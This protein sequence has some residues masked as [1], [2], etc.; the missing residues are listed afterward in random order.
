MEKTKS[1][2]YSDQQG[3][4]RA[5]YIYE[6]DDIETV[7]MKYAV[8]GNQNNLNSEAKCHYVAYVRG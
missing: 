6:S 8:E 5:K 3:D 1:S 2:E 4:V 7:H